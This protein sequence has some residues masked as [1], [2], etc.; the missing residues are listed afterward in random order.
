L[1]A[2]ISLFETDRQYLT[3]NSKTTANILAE[4]AA[5]ELSKSMDNPM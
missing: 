2:V 5:V 3:K 1:F 4:I